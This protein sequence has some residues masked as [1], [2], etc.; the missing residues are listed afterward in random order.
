MPP[1]VAPPPWPRLFAQAIKNGVIDRDVNA[2]F[3]HMLQKNHAALIRVSCPERSGKATQYTDFT[4]DFS[5]SSLRYFISI[6]HT[7]SSPS[8]K[9]VGRLLISARSKVGSFG[10]SRP[11]A[12]MRLN[13]EI[14]P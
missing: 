13:A 8:G 3:I 1:A 7:A 9:T 4:R 12:A 14:H 5:T 6:S 11:F 10:E 2:I